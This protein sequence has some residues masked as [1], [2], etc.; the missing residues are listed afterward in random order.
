MSS[1]GVEDHVP[2]FCICDKEVC[3]GFDSENRIDHLVL[4]SNLRKQALRM[5][6]WVSIGYHNLYNH[7]FSFA[8]LIVLV[9]CFLLLRSL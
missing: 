6:L 3:L 5:F 1:S 2:T 7:M 9:S 4:L 8:I